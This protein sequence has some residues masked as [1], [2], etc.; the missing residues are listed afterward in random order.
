MSST[1]TTPQSLTRSVDG[2]EVP[3]AGLYTLDPSHSEVGFQVKHLMVSKVRGNFTQFSG[4]VAIGDD[5]LASSVEVDIEAASIT[6][7]DETRDNHLRTGD[8]F[9]VDQHPVI[10]YRSTKVTPAGKGRYAVDGDL[11][12]RGVTLPVALDVAYEGATQDPWGNARLGFSASAVVDRDA[13]GL[14]WNQALETGGV[15]VGKKVTI[16][17]E[18][19]AIRQ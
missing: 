2:T 9:E 6:T 13:F 5:P 4:T 16:N 14:T 3:V 17:I 11:T 18:A 8:F 19:E 10:T 15:V 1:Q 7:R 12:I